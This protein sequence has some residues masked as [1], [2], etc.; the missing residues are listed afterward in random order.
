[1][2]SLLLCLGVIACGGCASDY[3]QLP[4]VPAWVA[5]TDATP[6]SENQVIAQT[7]R[8]LSVG[9]HVY[10]SD[11]EYVRVNHEWLLAMVDWS[12]DAAKML[13]FTYTA[14]SR[15]C[16]KF[17]M[18]LYLAM[19]SS[20]A[21]AGVELTPLVARMVVD[22][23]VAFAGVPSTPND[24]HEILGVVTDRPPYYY[25]LEPQPSAAP[26]LTPLNQYPNTILSVVFGDYNP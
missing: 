3:V 14:N 22:Q 15:N 18:A 16:T 25:V 10:A 7:D 9:G 20:A 26:R 17:S 13:H 11:S 1:M 5:P 21:N 23:K 8:V 2:R 19:T 4:R 12:A 6:V 24:R